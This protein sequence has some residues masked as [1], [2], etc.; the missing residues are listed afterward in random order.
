MLLK[1][2][3][4]LL[5]IMYIYLNAYAICVSMENSTTERATIITYKS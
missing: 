3:E 4:N 2:H 1:E 5:F